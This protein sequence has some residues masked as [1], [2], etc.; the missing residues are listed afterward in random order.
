MFKENSI[1]IEYTKRVII[2]IDQLTIEN[3]API[4]DPTKNINETR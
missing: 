4:K 1:Y 2:I 3:F